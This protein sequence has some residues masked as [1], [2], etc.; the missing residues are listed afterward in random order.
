[1]TSLRIALLAI[2]LFI[3]VIV[4]LVSYDKL[5]VKEIIGRKRAAREQ[6]D[7][8]QEPSLVSAD[9]REESELPSA[10]SRSVFLSPDHVLDDAVEQDV[11]IDNELHEIERAANM[12]LDLDPGLPPDLR[13]QS[14]DDR[15]DFVA[16]VPG[17]GPV[18]RDTALAVFRQNEYVLEKRR[19]IYGYNLNRRIWR[20]LEMEPP[21]ARYGDLRLAIQLNDRHGPI[22]ETELNKFAEMGLR[23]ADTLGRP[24]TFSTAFEAALARGQELDKFCGKYD[25]LAIVNIVANTDAGFLGRAVEREVT[26][27]GLEFGAMNIFHKRSRQDGKTLYSLANLAEPGEFDP[28]TFDTVRTPGLSLF[29]NIPCTS[30][31][32]RV[33][34]EMVRT[35]HNLCRT[36]GGTLRDPAKNVLSDAAIR[37]IAEQ[38]EWVASGME[39]EGFVPGEDT[40]ARLF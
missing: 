27:Q 18:P 35:A 9:S 37:K 28:D 34:E 33:F 13:E 19:G 21:T 10:S 2:G 24:V 26:K 22:M 6:P 36:L 12:K 5:R 15:I 32:A 38:I 31:P 17:E 14:P 29:M 7:D 4:A 3:V 16:D 8:W 1:M 39:K 40:V 11:E 20:N 25:M 23:L 30:D